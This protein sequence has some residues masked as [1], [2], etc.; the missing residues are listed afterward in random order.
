MSLISRTFVAD[1]ICGIHN[2]SDN[3]EISG[4]NQWQTV[5]SSA[6]PDKRCSS[7]GNGK[8][9]AGELKLSKEHWI[10]VARKVAEKIRKDQG[11]D[12][13]NDGQPRPGRPQEK[14]PRLVS[15]IRRERLCWSFHVAQRNKHLNCLLAAPYT[16]L[17]FHPVYLAHCGSGAYRELFCA[18]P[19]TLAISSSE[20]AKFLTLDLTKPR[21]RYQIAST[22]PKGQTR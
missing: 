12:P 18:R 10:S 13:R 9:A 17:G 19:L 7:K 14:V 5:S 2:N 6:K 22:C 16:G 4:Q 11:A 3:D 1:G 15:S 8:D 21:D 20:G